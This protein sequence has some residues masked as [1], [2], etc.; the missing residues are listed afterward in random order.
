V[1]PQRSD[2][3][4]I[5]QRHR[6]LQL[7][8]AKGG[9]E[10]DHR[11]GVAA[12]RA[13]EPTGDVG[14][15]AGPGAPFHQR[16]DVGAVESVQLEPRQA[17]ELKVRPLTVARGEEHADPL[18]QQPSCGEQQGVHRSDVQP[19]SVVDQYDE[20]QRLGGCGERA[21]HARVRREP[22]CDDWRPQPKR[23]LERCPLSFRKASDVGLQRPQQER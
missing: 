8:R 14:R 7:R 4:R 22:V 11:E 23:R 1:I 18:I 6:T 9:R 19:V 16:G 10:F 17:R 3:K 15:R 12:G 20:G 2:G 13:S 5:L 21:Q